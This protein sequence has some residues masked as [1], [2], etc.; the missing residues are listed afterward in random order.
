VAEKPPYVESESQAKTSTL[1]LKRDSV[2]PIRLSKSAE[3]DL[4]SIE[5]WL[6]QIGAGG[7]AA[8]KFTR[9]LQAIQDLAVQ[10]DVWPIVDFPAA[11]KDLGYRKRV[12]GDYVVV[13]AIRGPREAPYVAIW[14]VLGPGRTLQ[15]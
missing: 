1:R 12:V 9:V 14:R 7:H 10:A 6:T 2:L 15:V 8:A 4:D 5:E 13:Y 11:A 3:R